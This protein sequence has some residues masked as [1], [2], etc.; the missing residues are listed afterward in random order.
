MKIR[1]YSDLHLEFG[2]YASYLNERHGEDL[3]ILAGDIHVGVDGVI[4][5]KHTFPHVPVVYVMGNH[6]YYGENFDKLVEECKIVAQD[7]TVRVL[8]REALDASG[9]RV[10][11][12]TLWTDY[13]VMGSERIDEAMTWAEGNLAD[14]WYIRA[15]GRPFKPLD[16]ALEF[17]RSA[18]WLDRQIQESDGPVIVVTH[19]APSIATSPPRFAGQISVPSFHSDAEHLLRPPV[20][21]WAHGHTHHNCDVAVKGV[22]VVTNQWGYPQE[23]APGFRQDGIFDVEI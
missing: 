5:A 14:F 12:T 2:R 8:E 18:E 13:E 11:A 7:S 17:A 23:G 15:H 6:E 4:W 3:V 19:H 22:R 16:A 10:L 9:V 1:I 21:L 20:R